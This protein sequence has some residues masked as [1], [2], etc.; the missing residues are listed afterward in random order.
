MSQV[1]LWKKLT[2]VNYVQCTVLEVKV[3]EGLGTTI[4]VV[5]VNGTLTVGDTIV[6]CGINGPIVTTIRALLTPQPM[7]E[8]R[9]KT[10]YV[11]HDF[12]QGSQGIKIAAN[13]VEKACAGTSLMVLEK[14]DYADHIKAEVMKDLAKV[15]QLLQ[16]LGVVCSCKRPHWAPSRPCSSSCE[17]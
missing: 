8:I 6:V 5:L 16:I 12:I 3:I 2:F 7:K 13:D 9:V 17:S 1:H 15:E 11:K 10:E 14:E 4:D